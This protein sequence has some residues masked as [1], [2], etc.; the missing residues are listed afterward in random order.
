MRQI[1]DLKKKEENVRKKIMNC[2]EINERINNELCNDTIKA[3]SD[4]ECLDK[5]KECNSLKKNI[6]ELQTVLM[7]NAINEDIY[8]KILDDYSIK[9]ISP[10]LKGVIRGN[11]FNSIVRKYI[12]DLNLDNNK[13]EIA[14]E[15][16]S[17]IYDTSE[18]PDWYILEKDSNKLMI[19]M[20]QLDLW[21]GGQ[22]INRAS[23][24]IINFPDNSDKL[25]LVCVIANLIKISS[26][27]NK[28]FK[29]FQKGFQ[30]NTLCYLK[31]LKTIIYNFFKV[32]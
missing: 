11:K 8:K 29:L 30:D 3:L 23:K 7:N 26:E 2:K 15:E 9:L 24:Y 14:F 1:L 25:K 10:G 12:L 4:N 5:Y 28:T 19:G 22:Q 17:S 6:D 20:N 31:N 32:L 21:G 13:Y 27:K 16:K 18:I